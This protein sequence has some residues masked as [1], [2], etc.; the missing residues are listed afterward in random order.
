[1]EVIHHDNW[2][3]KTGYELEKGN[4]KEALYLNFKNIF[5]YKT[6]DNF[7]NHMRLS[8]ICYCIIKRDK[9]NEKMIMPKIKQLINHE[10]FVNI[11]DNLHECI[12]GQKKVCYFGVIY[13]PKN[14]NK[15]YVIGSHC[16]AHFIDDLRIHCEICDEIFTMKFNS[17][18]LYKKSRYV[19]SK[20][21]TIE[22]LINDLIE[23][24]KNQRND[25]I[26]QMKNEQKLIEFRITKNIES[27]RFKIFQSIIDLE[28]V[29]RCKLFD[30]EYFQITS[31]I[32]NF[33][34]MK[35]KILIKLRERREQEENIRKQKYAESL[36]IA[37]QKREL[38][39]KHELE[40]HK[41]NME[42]FYNKQNLIQYA[43]EIINQKKQ[44]EDAI[45]Y[46]L[47]K[48]QCMKCISD[49]IDI[50]R[51]NNITSIVSYEKICEAC[52]KKF[53]SYE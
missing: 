36:I 38:R 6:I 24:E 7:Y 49:K 19:C 26:I 31:I 14:K 2:E 22:D 45:W 20:C 3:S 41:I 40:Q 12:C 39:E 11:P 35:K 50:S 51:R 43:N 52:G 16:M 4:K 25:L 34:E 17:N 44:E 46:L 5:G 47:K 28:Q 23:N 27:I 10:L 1:M 18:I 42:K 15:L 48:K 21:I 13:H 30:N 29:N 9:E 8:A 33:N 53:K 37:K 32:E